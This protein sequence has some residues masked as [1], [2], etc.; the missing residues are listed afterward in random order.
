MRTK[1]TK[2]KSNLSKQVGALEQD[3]LKKQAELAKLRKKMPQEEVPD[4]TLKGPSSKSIKLSQLFGDKE[5][6]IVIHNMGTSCSYCTM[7][8]DGINGVVQHL[9]D[10]AGLVLVSPDSPKVQGE[11]AK[12]RG[13]KFKMVS[14]E[15]SSFSKDLNF[16]VEKDGKTYAHPGVSTFHKKPDG[17][18]VRIAKAPFGPG[19]AFCSPWHF[20]DLLAKGVN[21]WEPKYKY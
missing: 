16:A 6:L 19:D 18:I 3:L 2:T 14:D 1:T 10:R 8:A 9:Q 20:F 7:W 12:Q 11:F 21:G 5:D 15:G 4:Y 17:T 13:W